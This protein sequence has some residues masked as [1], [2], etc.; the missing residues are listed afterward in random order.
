VALSAVEAAAETAV[1]QVDVLVDLDIRAVAAEK[2]FKIALRCCSKQ[3]TDDFDLGSQRIQRDGCHCVRVR[4]TARQLG[5]RPT[6]GFL[7]DGVLVTHS[8]LLHQPARRRGRLICDNSDGRS[9]A[10]TLEMSRR[11][12]G[13]RLGGEERGSAVNL[14]LWIVQGLLVAVFGFSALVKGTQSK[15][16][17]LSL[18]MTG[19][20]DLPLLAMRFTAF[21]ELLGIVGL[22]APRVTGIAPMLTPLAAI[23]L[24]VIMVLAARIHLRLGEPRTAAGNLVLLAL[25]LVVAVGR[26]PG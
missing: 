19:V 17:T 16:R 10:P 5:Q 22:V 6:A 23:G 18:G 8:V 4:F 21:F 13:R 7:A 12:C 9:P 25:C 15:E 11:R 2:E 3:A 1:R 20:V 14:V 24:G 26:W